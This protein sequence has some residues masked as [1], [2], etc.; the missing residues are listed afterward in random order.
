L[1]HPF[2]LHLLSYFLH[3]LRDQDNQRER[4]VYFQ[5]RIQHELL[6]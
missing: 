5:F 6:K 2:E 3:S 4:N 1:L